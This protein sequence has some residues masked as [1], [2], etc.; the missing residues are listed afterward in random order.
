MGEIKLLDCTLRDGGYL[1][2][3]EFG[4]DEIVTIFERLISAGV[5][6]VEIG[7]LD[8]RRDYDY[9]RTILPDAKS[10]NQTYAGLAA[11]DTMVVGMIDYGTC[12]IERIC[13][14]NESFMDGIRVIF[15]K[16]VMTEALAFCGKIKELGYAVFVQAVSITSYDDAEF[17]TLLCEVN[18]LEPYAFSIVDTYGLL[19]KNQLIHYFDM[20]NDTLKETIGIGYHSH[21][22]FQLG[23][24]NCME[25]LEKDISRMLVLDGTLY[26]MGKGAGNTPVELLAMYLNENC[27][28]KYHGSQLLEAIDVT[29]SECYRKTPWGYSLKFF[30]A[31]SNDCHPNYVAAL[32]E[33][34]KLSVKSVNEILAAIPQE[35]KLLFDAKLIE[36]LYVEHQK[37]ACNDEAAFERLKALL[38][39]QKI[40]LIGPGTAAER[41]IEDISV[42]ITQ[43]KPVVIAIN[44]LPEKVKADY[45]FMSNA[46]RY[47]QLAT[48]LSASA[49]QT[50]ATSNVTRAKGDFDYVFEYGRLL[51]EEAYL[52]DNP[53]L[54]ILRLLNEMQIESVALAGF[55]GYSRFVK[56]NYV[57]P[58]M[59]YVFSKEKAEVINAD[60][61]AGI[62][63]IGMCCPIRFITESLYEAML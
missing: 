21:N 28:K 18:A 42:Y 51:D 32:M 7:F 2:D 16:H 13:P 31:A 59:E 55:D 22:N 5:D 62:R 9:N 45:V 57:N 41:Q 52:R 37:I 12:N 49:V 20:A 33:K 35:K 8:E 19:H 58:N 44:F 4:H 38:Q 34:K 46:K 26:G 27:G 14:K 60:T 11:K 6:I 17:A 24:A 48:K 54:M 53:L 63:R 61:V 15:K 40:L 30:I 56:T 1:N 36:E 39:H 23:Y 10:V 25:L 50:I 29:V 43:E 3:W 47:V